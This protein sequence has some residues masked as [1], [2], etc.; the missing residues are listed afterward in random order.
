MSFERRRFLKSA[1]LTAV[2]AGLALGMGRAVLGQKKWLPAEKSIGYQIPIKAQQDPLFHFTEGTFRPY[3]NDIFQAPDA[4][5]EM[6]TLRLVGVNGYKPKAG[7]MVTTAR[8]P[9][10]RETRSFALMFKAEKQL[11]PFTTI[12]KVRHPAL[13]KFDLFLTP[14]EVDGEFFY[15][16]VFNHL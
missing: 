8:A 12:H 1:T 5:G 4:R 9:K 16:A 10:P 7:S 2:S 11:P 13:G 6:V 15:E 3:I 14:R